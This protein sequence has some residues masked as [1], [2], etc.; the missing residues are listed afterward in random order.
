MC[1]CALT[2]ISVRTYLSFR[3]SEDVFKFED[4][5]VSLQWVLKG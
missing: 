3:L 2:P 4:I 5:L 1:V